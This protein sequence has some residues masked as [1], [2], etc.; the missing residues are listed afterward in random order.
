[1]DS[2]GLKLCG[3]GEWLLEKHGTATRRSWRML[4]LGVDAGTG[5]IVASTL[6][7]KDV[8]GSTKSQDVWHR[9]PATAPTARIAFT[10]AS[11]RHVRPPCRATRPRPHPRSATATY[12]KHVAEHGRMA[13]QNASGHNRRARPKPP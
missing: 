5:R 1:V 2:A 7:A 11:S 10:P 13:W 8:D 3:K 4:H 6:A 12:L 9:S